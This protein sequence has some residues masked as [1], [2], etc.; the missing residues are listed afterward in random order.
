MRWCA[1]A[2]RSATARARA[3]SDIGYV[4]FAGQVGWILS[5]LAFLRIVNGAVLLAADV[6]KARWLQSSHVPALRGAVD[7]LFS[8]S[9][10]SSPQLF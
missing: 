2:S 1:L 3:A 7:F 4:C 6:G 9:S 10:G 8:S 5:G